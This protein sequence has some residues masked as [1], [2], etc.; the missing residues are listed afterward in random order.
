MIG[1]LSGRGRAY[2]LKGKEF[3]RPVYKYRYEPYEHKCYECSS[4]EGK[5]I[6]RRWVNA[7]GFRGEWIIEPCDC[8]DG[9][10][11]S[12][13]TVG[14]DEVGVEVRYYSLC[15]TAVLRKGEGKE[16]KYIC[17]ACMRVNGL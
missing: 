16:V 3:E 11:T 1:Y 9:I 8:N 12:K 4:Y 17:E 15:G 13:R 5:R 7:P 10:V 6:R 2:H 14:R